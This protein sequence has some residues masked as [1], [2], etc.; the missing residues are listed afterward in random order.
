MGERPKNTVRV[1]VM[2][3][4][5]RNGKTLGAKGYDEVTKQEHFRII[6]GNLD[7]GETTN[8][9]IRREVREELKCDIENLKLVDV[10]DNHYTYNGHKGHDVIFLYKGNLSSEK[11]YEQDIIC[12]EEPDCTFNAEWIPVV[13]ILSGKTTLYPTYNWKKILLS[14]N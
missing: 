4:F 7:F 8:K 2:C 11:L 5:T 10:I 9:G 14:D 3:L 1:K 12:I 13:D 6:G